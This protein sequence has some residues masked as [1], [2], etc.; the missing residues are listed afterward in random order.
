M[1]ARSVTAINVLCFVKNRV[2]N[3]LCGAEVKHGAILVLASLLVGLSPFSA[4]AQSVACSQEIIVQDGESLATIAARTLGTQPGYQAIIDA[5]NAQAAVD[6]RPL[7]HR[8]DSTRQYVPARCLPGAHI[9]LL[10][11]F[12]YSLTKCLHLLVY[13]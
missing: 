7:A 4:Q 11:G 2:R 3:C 5:T 8:Q 6:S 10:P 12:E 13:G 1:M 9:A